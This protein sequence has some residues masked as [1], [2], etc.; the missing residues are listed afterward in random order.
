M[1]KL[2]SVLLLVIFSGA[3]SL[4]DEKVRRVQEELRKRNLYFGEIDGQPSKETQG[5]V[6]RY[7]QRKGFAATGS[8][9]PDTLRS[10]NLAAPLP[11]APAWPDELVLK[12]DAA[13]ELTEADYQRLEEAAVEPIGDGPDDDLRGPDEEEA[14]A[15]P[16]PPP[17]D[18]IPREQLEKFLKDYLAACQKNDLDAELAFYADSVDYFHHGKVDKAFIRRD[19]QRYYDRWPSRVYELQEFDVR[20]SKPDQ[21]LLKFRITFKV[22]NDK[23]HVTGRTSN[24]FRVQRNGS[25]FA[26][27][28]VKEQRLRE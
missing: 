2:F 13:R 10:L 14:T 25:S 24:S 9:D 23:H 7:Q 15:A 26:F 6:R 12:S 19:V 18:A 1:K 22:R 21:A 11:T 8:I 5:A 27:T 17:P 20:G 4:A 16:V 3:G 28:S